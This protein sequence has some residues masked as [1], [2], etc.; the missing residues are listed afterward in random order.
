MNLLDLVRAVLAA[1]PP[2]RPGEQPPP[3]AVKQL[4]L[5]AFELSGV[6]IDPTLARTLLGAYALLEPFPRF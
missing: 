3:D 5:D 2:F 1:H 6:S 4:Q